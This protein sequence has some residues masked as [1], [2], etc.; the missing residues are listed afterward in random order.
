MYRLYYLAF[1]LAAMIVFSAPAGD[2]GSKTPQIQNA[3]A[4][5]TVAPA[6]CCGDPPPPPPPGGGRG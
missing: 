5:S 1:F 4:V 3:P 2:T 6:D